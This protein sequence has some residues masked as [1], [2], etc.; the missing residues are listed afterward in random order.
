MTERTAQ[1]AEKMIAYDEGDLRRIEHFMKVYGYASAIGMLEKLDPVTQELLEI[2][3]LL[4][5]I[6]IKVS[7]KKYHSS[8]G[9]YQELEGPGEARKLLEGICP[10]SKITDRVCWLIGHHHTYSN[11]QDIDHQILVEADFLVNLSED[12]A[13]AKSIRH[14]L[15][16][17]F[18]TQSGIRFLKSMYQE[19]L[20]DLTNYSFPFFPAKK[21]G[22]VPKNR[23]LWLL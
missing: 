4:H 1:I 3:A 17:I 5:D 6:G 15:E 22:S 13:S 8:A 7:E 14:A 9:T 10:D 20:S 16:H 21:Q 11:I 23:A 12:H 2:A 18:R 19:A